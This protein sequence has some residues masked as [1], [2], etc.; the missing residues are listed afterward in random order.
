M[1]VE[2][3]E[4]LKL[5]MLNQTILKR[6]F[7]KFYSSRSSAL[8]FTVSNLQKTP[9]SLIS[10]TR[11][12]QTTPSILRRQPFDRA[13]TGYLDKNGNWQ[14]HKEHAESSKNIGLK[15][16]AWFIFMTGVA[17]ASEP[18]YRMFCTETGRGGLGTD[19]SG[20]KYSDVVEKMAVV[21]ERPLRVHFTA[22]K[23]SLLEWSFKPEQ[24]HVDLF[25]GETALIFYK[26]KNPT[27]KHVIGVSTYTIEPYESGAYFNKIQ[28]FCFEQQM[29]GPNEEV[30]L[31]V[32]FFIDPE[33][34]EDPLLS[35]VFDIQLCYTF[36]EVKE[37]DELP[38][39]GFPMHAK[40]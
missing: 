31:P 38:L 12:L 3:T 33:L 34:D 36:F 25:P 23:S 30:D 40:I 21:R 29:L 19:L 8:C 16:V 2:L 26:A 6:S 22:S 11:S 27:D 20:D 24:D 18:L 14:W 28:C 5:T 9:N 4:M 37:G 10:Q 15:F 13:G 35:R 17:V 32:F 7:S 39:P 1:G